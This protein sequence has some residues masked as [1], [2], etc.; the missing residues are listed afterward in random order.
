[1]KGSIIVELD[2]RAVTERFSLGSGHTCT[3]SSND[4]VTRGQCMMGDTQESSGC[5]PAERVSP[6]QAPLLLAAIVKLRVKGRRG[7]AHA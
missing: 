4:V 2:D 7:E 6:S 1:M 3:D 5:I